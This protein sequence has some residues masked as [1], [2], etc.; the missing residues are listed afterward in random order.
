MDVEDHIG[1]AYD[2]LNHAEVMLEAGE[3]MLASELL[4]GAV[5]QATIAVAKRRG[6]RYASHT[7]MKDA[8]WQV[9]VELLDIEIRC[10]FAVAEKCRANFYHD[11]MNGQEI[12]DAGERLSYYV[13][14]VSAL[15]S[16]VG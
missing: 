10:G 6:W 5:S 1:K 12:K 14:R 9:A 7:A 16:D 2:F 4:W 13:N 3:P 8:A 15:A 11:F